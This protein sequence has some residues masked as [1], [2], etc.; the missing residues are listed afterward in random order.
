MTPAK[1]Y[2]R[3]EAAVY[4]IQNPGS[5]MIPVRAKHN[6]IDPNK[7]LWSYRQGGWYRTSLP[8]GELA[9]L[10]SHLFAW[11]YVLYQPDPTPAEPEFIKKYI[12]QSMP[13]TQEQAA[14]MIRAQ[15]ILDL[16][17]SKVKPL[18]EDL[19]ILKDMHQMAFSS[20][21]PGRPSTNKNW[22]KD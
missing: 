20:A 10:E 2:T 8:P 17:E 4:L 18:E 9:S 3:D 22:L 6:G 1:T 16:V 19:R 13:H 21:I 14:D 11:D 15:L 5:Y 7:E 12:G